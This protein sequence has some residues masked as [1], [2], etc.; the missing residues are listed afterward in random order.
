MG[1]WLALV[2]IFQKLKGNIINGLLGWTWVK[3]GFNGSDHNTKFEDNNM[4][5][6]MHPK[7]R[8]N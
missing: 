4:L 6:P 8:K 3:L 7:S 1:F 5:Y 2:E